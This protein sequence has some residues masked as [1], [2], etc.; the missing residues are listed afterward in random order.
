MIPAILAVVNE[1]VPYVAQII[2]DHHA[3]TGQLPTD[4]EIVAKLH[5]DVFNRR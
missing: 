5:A 4:E 2:R 1:L 3:Q